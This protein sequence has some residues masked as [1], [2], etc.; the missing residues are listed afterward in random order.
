M[1]FIPT[2][3]FKEKMIAGRNIST[4]SQPQ[5]LPQLPNPE[6]HFFYR[7]SDENRWISEQIANIYTA[8]PRATM[9]VLA[10]NNSSLFKVEEYLH[11][12]GLIYNLYTKYNPDRSRTHFRRITLATIHASKGLEWDYVF[13]MNCHDDCLPS[14]KSDEDL[15]AERRLFYVAVTRPR[16]HLVFTYSRHE[17]ALSRFVREIPRPFLQYHG[18]C[19]YKMSATEQGRT[20]L[21]L[22]DH[23][24]SLDGAE[25]QKLRDF[26]AIPQLTNLS[27]TTT[28]LYD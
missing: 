25:W 8:N 14:R 7:A 4:Q 15:I 28:A 11:K 3:P 10:R 2:L 22:S 23:I 9:A 19:L 27:Q 12:Q 16:E 6:V 26:N 5:P 21:S 18:I 1:R 24:G 20:L 13:L 17:P